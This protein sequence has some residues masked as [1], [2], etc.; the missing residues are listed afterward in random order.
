[1]DI[2]GIVSSFEIVFETRNASSDTEPIIIETDAP[3]CKAFID[4]SSILHSPNFINKKV[5]P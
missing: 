3:K 4:F 2:V 1:M 5:Y